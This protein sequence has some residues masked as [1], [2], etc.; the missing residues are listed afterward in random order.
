MAT[1][2]R[3]AMTAAG[4]AAAA[5]AYWLYG[6][7]DAAKNRSKAKSW[8]LKARADVMDSVEKAKDVDYKAYLKIVN[9]AAKRYSAITGTRNA[10]IRQLVSDLKSS[11][12][13]MQMQKT[14]AKRASAS[15]KKR[16]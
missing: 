7:K 8:M 4:M 15:R 14:P 16:R 10:E 2:R 11:W 9:N 3:V 12:S 5:G 13:H 1:K 6:S